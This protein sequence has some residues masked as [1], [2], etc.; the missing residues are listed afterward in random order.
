MEP[1]SEPPRIGGT[2]VWY[3]VICQRQVWL[4]SR[5]VEPD[6]EDE[7][8][9][10][11]R[12]IDQN[13]YNRERH[14]IEF[15]NSKYDILREEGGTL[16]LGEIKK[17]SRSLDASRLQLAHYLYTLEKAGVKARGELLFPKEKRREN[18]ELNPELIKRLNDT[19][20][21]IER[22]VY[23]ERPPATEKCRYCRNC[24]Y[25]EYCWS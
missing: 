4:M 10:M 5:A 22:I 21:E 13:T 7:F 16:V 6:R 25:G 17:S 3:Y 19:Y 11:G 23:L 24:A 2:L 18:V 8:L 20:F 1:F 14:A 9:M 15:G 12:L